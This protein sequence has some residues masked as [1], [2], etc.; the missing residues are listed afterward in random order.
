MNEKIIKLFEIW[1]QHIDQSELQWNLD[2]DTE[3]YFFNLIK[4]IDDC[5]NSLR[6]TE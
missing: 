2:K 5:I 1:K 4:E 3:T 6:N